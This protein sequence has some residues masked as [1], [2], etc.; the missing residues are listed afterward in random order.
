MPGRGYSKNGLFLEDK[1]IKKRLMYR[2]FEDKE[3]LSSL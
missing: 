1:G 2:I 3:V